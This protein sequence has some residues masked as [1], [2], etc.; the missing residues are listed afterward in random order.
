MPRCTAE[1]PD[2][3]LCERIVGASQTF[4]YAH[5][6]QRAQ[7]RSRAASKAARS[8][9]PGNEIAHLKEELVDLKSQVLDGAVDRQ[10]AEA[11][12]KIVRAIRELIEQ[13]RKQRELIELADLHEQ[14][15]EI[16]RAG[17]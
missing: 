9:M 11:V 2:G 6:P 17:S 13:D 15:Q 8:K 16:K 14:L 10:D 12:L 7:A 3:T 4:C 1:K 5:N